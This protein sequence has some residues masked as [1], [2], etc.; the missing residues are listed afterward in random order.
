[1]EMNFGVE[2]TKVQPLYILYVLKRFTDEK[3]TLSQ[4]GIARK[5]RDLGYCPVRKDKNG[6]YKERNLD[7]RKSIGKDLKLLYDMGYP[8]HGVE[9]ELDED[10]N[11]LPATRG[12]IWI[13]KEISDEKL[14][15]L[16]N[17]IKYNA[18]MDESQ[19]KEFIESLISLGSRTFREKNNA[20]TM[21]D[22]GRI[23]HVEGSSLFKQLSEIDK[24][25]ALG[26]KI[27]FTYSKLKRN[28][29]KFVYEAEKEYTVS[30]Y[31]V[32][33]NKGN[34]YLVCHNHEEN[35]IWHLR[36][37][38]M[39][40]VKM[41]NSY[42]LPKTETELKGVDVGNY[43][44]KHP[45]M[46][47]GDNISVELKIDKNQVGRLIEAFGT[48]FS[49]IKETED[50]LTVKVYAGELDM[51]HWAIQYGSF[52]EVLKPQSLR[53]KIRIQIESMAFNYKTKDGDKY[54]EAIRNAIRTKVLDLSG[55]DLSGKKE[56]FGLKTIKKVY[57]SNNNIDNVDFLKDYHWLQELQ[58]ENNNVTDL[59]CLSEL[60]GLRKATLKNLKL[61][62]LD[63]VHDKYF[64]KLFLDV[65]R[66]TDYSALLNIR[67]K[68]CLIFA[69]RCE[70]Y[71]N[72]PWQE[73]IKEKIKFAFE[74][75]IS[76]VAATES[77]VTYKFA[78]PMIFE[79]YPFNFLKYAFGNWAIKPDKIIEVENAVDRVFDKF[80][81]NE[82]K[83]L[84]VCYKQRIT[85]KK[86]IIENLVI[87]E[88]EYDEIINAIEEK[89]RHSQICDSLKEFFIDGALKGDFSEAERL[90]NNIELSENL[91]KLEKKRK[92]NK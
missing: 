82:K 8:I 54:S 21:V 67:N 91:E 78:N 40:D 30:P 87:S 92:S 7:E 45:L 51:F 41:I 71:Q 66:E 52:V 23:F 1:M 2:T 56:H 26:K 79:K 89:I 75:E 28:G 27:R 64:S 69:D 63:F 70:M 9:R 62:N 34:T 49:I 16:I 4:E 60:S 42:A 88:K 55:I 19:K 38:K 48:N 47:S 10:G 3:N 15:W 43:V 6:N 57:L 39:K 29:S 68:D 32:I 74:R 5:L 84:E 12:K 86:T 90:L 46:F 53:D 80:T 50:Y 14:S 22:G 85:D 33:V 76:K 11:E 20:K 81:S 18:F 24:A 77:E 58:L 65:G 83:Y 35:K 61:K 17:S 59:T 44:T 37:D 72:I 25:I 73:F 13:E 31:W 36:V